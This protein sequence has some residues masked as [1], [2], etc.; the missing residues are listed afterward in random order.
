MAHQTM[1]KVTAPTVSVKEP[2]IEQDKPEVMDVSTP[3]FI[4]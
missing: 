2:Q 4:E 1:S 3:S